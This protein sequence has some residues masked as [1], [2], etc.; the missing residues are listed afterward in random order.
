M[1]RFQFL[2]WRSLF[3]KLIAIVGCSLIVMFTVV[4]FMTMKF[5]QNSYIS[6]YATETRLLLDQIAQNYDKLHHQSV[7][8]LTTCR[9]NS[10][11]KAFLADKNQDGKAQSTIIFNMK[12]SLEHINLL[13]ERT[14]STLI[15]IGRN[16]N[17]YVSNDDK[18]MMTRQEIW[19][20]EPV[21]HALEH[22]DQIT[23]SFVQER[24][25]NSGTYDQSIA[26]VEILRDSEDSVYGTALLLINLHSFEEYY[27]SIL[28][29][30]LNSVF[31]VDA[32]DFVF[33][34]NDI[35]MIGQSEPELMERVNG[36]KGS[37][38]LKENGHTIMGEYLPYYDSYIF[39]VIDDSQFFLQAS[40]WSLIVAVGIVILIVTCAIIY[41][42]L[43]SAFRP[44][45]KLRAKMH[46]IQE[47]NFEDRLEVEGEGE[48][49]ELAISYNYMQEGLR[50]YVDELMSME[51]EKR[52]LEIHSLQMQINPHFM[53]NTLT[54]FKFLAWQKRDK[55][56][57]E[58]LD[59]FIAL[60]QETLGNKEEK[61][62]VAQEVTNLKNYVHI[63][64]IRFGDH[65]QVN[66]N[67]EPAALKCICPKLIL[68]P[69]V[70]NA[71]FHAFND[72]ENGCI[73]IFGRIVEDHLLF[74][75]IDNG[76]GMDLH[77]DLKKGT[78]F[79]GVGISNVNERIVLLY[80]KQYGVHIESVPGAGTFVTIELPAIQETLDPD[81]EAS[82]AGVSSSSAKPRRAP[83]GLLN[84]ED[85]LLG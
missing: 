33:S 47:G 16:G 38:S 82:A 27:A 28:D 67:I 56:L 53:Y 65:I 29:P 18:R 59:A 83:R 54:S 75:I 50:R 11:V 44:L 31:I 6:L 19:D 51:K 45:E 32:N 26:A 58:S 2:R 81:S 46:E 7:D 68:Q 10:Y 48:I 35:Q 77:S 20:S 14:L 70:E 36:R 78:K 85:D 5:M 74:E 8:V 43:N 3:S 34:S 61:I 12:K 41:A 62:T 4:M 22:P 17:V 66:Y 42:L 24:M 64:K 72:Q 39:C 73:D 37:F 23:Y 80:G 69:F 15:L 21:Q 63:L 25:V 57:V 79:S 52:L 84:D 76:K 40:N 60:L 1:K 49:A 9:N 13:N 71:F 55:E 30:S